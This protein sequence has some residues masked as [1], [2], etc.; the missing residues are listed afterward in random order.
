MAEAGQPIEVI[1][2]EQAAVAATMAA[3]PPARFARLDRVLALATEIP[4]A[5]LVTVETLVLLAGV[6][7]RYVFN[8]SSPGPT[9][10]PRFCFYG[11]RC[12][13]P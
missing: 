9:S 4:A 11:S 6:V 5:I 2:S 8:Q 12:S 7:S 1:A 10:S 3:P 13:V